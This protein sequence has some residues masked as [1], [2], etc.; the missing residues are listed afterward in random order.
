MKKI[1]LI[2][3]SLLFIFTSAQLSSCGKGSD[4]PVDKIIVLL[5]EATEKTENI[6]SMAELTNVKNIVSP[7]DIWTI[8]KENS[9]YKLTKGDKEK[10]K[11]SYNRLLK[12]A[13]EKSSEF[14]PSEELKKVVKSQLDLMMQAVDSN[15]ENAETLGDIRSLN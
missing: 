4:S 8:I 11:K 7:E 15:I 9:D 3:I 6:N 5:D 2:F 13:Y 14:S 12:V 1:T 10:L